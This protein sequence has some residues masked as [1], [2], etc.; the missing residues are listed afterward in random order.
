MTAALQ[1]L[2]GYAEKQ[3]R[4]VLLELGDEQLPPI[5]HLE[6]P[7]G[8]VACA[9]PSWRGPIEKQAIM[10]AVRK[11]ARELQAT[12]I[13]WFGETWIAKHQ[14]PLTD[15]HA[16]RQT[17]TPPS[18]DPSRREYVMATA[19]DGTAVLTRA[20]EIVRSRPGG[21]IVA[22]VEDKMF[23]DPDSSFSGPL[24]DGLIGGVRR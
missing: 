24:I 17:Y 3:A 14:A 4:K 9:C 15:W 7:T 5:Y 19:T 16:Q 22:L 13:M 6:T 8:G 20:W 23:S 1:K 12:A 21:P 2:L 11:I 10:A 18:E